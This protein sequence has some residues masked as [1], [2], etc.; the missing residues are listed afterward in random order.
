MK[1]KVQFL[2]INPEELEKTDQIEVYDIRSPRFLEISGDTMI[3]GGDDTLCIIYPKNPI[4]HYVI[5]KEAKIT[6]GKIFGNLLYFA[7]S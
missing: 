6:L 7:V 4:P 1:T 2:Q 5:I 3:L